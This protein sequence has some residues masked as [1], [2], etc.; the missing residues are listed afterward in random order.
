MCWMLRSIGEYLVFETLVGRIEWWRLESGRYVLLPPDEGIYK[1]VLFPGL[2]LDA[3]GLRSV[4]ARMLIAT[5]EQGMG[6][7]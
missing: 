3:E 4:N 2:W 1:S 7:S 5:L 6:A